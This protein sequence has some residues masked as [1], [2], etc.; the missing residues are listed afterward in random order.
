MAR[1]G[2]SQE[3]LDA[4]NNNKY[5]IYA[6]NNRIVYSNEFKFLFMKEFESGKAPKDIFHA[7]GFDTEAL[8]SKRIERAT[9]RW[10]ESYA[11]GT[12]GNYDD[13][14]LRAIHAAN[15]AKR[16]KG[17]IQGTVALQNTQIKELEA[18]IQARDK[19]IA[20]LRLRI[21]TMRMAKDQQKVF[22][23]KKE[24]AIINL[25]RA[26]VELLLTVGFIDRDKYDYSIRD[27]GVFYQLIHDTVL[28]YDITK[29]LTDLCNILGLEQ[30]G[31]YK[32]LKKKNLT[33]INCASGSQDT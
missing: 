28:K 11:A 8:G 4:L 15:E 1:G 22:C 26:K 19:E 12:L 24:S 33:A 5:V 3:E 9:A 14:H 25:L 18:K 17:H 23:V 6:E 21:H 29:G 10:K 20:K 13:A 31:Y 2:F 30:R 16:K 32:Y 27:K 7:A